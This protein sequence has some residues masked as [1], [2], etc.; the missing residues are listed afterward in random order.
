MKNIVVIGSGQLG[1]RHLQGL[2]KLNIEAAIEVVEPNIESVNM[3][4]ERLN[5]I[6]QNDSIK[7]I[8]FKSRIEELSDNIDLCIIATN[9]DVRLKVVQELLEKKRVKNIVLEKVL[10]QRLADYETANSLFKASDVNVWVNC[11]RRAFAIYKQLKQRLTEEPSIEFRVV[12]GHWGLGCNAIHFIDLFSM[13][14]GE[15]NYSIIDNKLDDEVIA[16]K[17][18]GFIEFTG[19]ITG[20]FKNGHT[21]DLVSIKNS[22]QPLLIEI[23]T[24]KERLLVDETNGKM[25]VFHT[26]NV[27]VDTISF[28]MVYQS[29]LT[30][31]TANQILTTSQCDL[32]NYADSS[33][34]HQTLLEF[35]L[36]HIAASTGRR[37]EECPIT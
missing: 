2:T 27:L 21:F 15:V 6:E 37:P 18:N 1:S 9:S 17:R 32:P 34:I 19:N 13:L 5:S 7:R 31:L 10:F 12:G 33:I 25:S 26:D 23:I 20:Q 28:D 24:S 3:T 4:K 36:D 16:S 11:A 29:N 14:C 35:L 8:T 22:S 30:D